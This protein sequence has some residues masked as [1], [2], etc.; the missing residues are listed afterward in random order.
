MTKKEMY[1]AIHDFVNTGATDVDK[2]EIKAFCLH[3]IELMEHRTAK[4]KETA[5]KK[6]AS[7]NDELFEKI[8]GCLGD[9]FCSI[10]AIA[11]EVGV[12]RAKVISRLSALVK[13]DRAI[14]GEVITEDENGKK[15]KAVGYKAA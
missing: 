12:S 9:E 10:D 4:A 11:T 15:K 7:A 5:A 1:K 13:Q 8:A 3:E 2:E 14:K 6:R